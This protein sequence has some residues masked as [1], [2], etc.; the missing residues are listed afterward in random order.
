MTKRKRGNALFFFVTTL[1]LFTGASIVS[2]IIPIA[3]TIERIGKNYLYGAI[4]KSVIVSAKDILEFSS[5]SGEPVSISIN[6][7][8]ITSF[9]DD[10]SWCVKIED[11]HSERFIYSE[12]R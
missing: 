11:A 2:M 10:D 3:F 4:S 6:S 5:S 8:T 12:R 7:A 9:C 1:F